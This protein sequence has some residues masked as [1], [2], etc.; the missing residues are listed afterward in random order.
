VALLVSA[1]AVALEGGFCLSGI[2]VGREL[3]TSSVVRCTGC[4]YHRRD[5]TSNYLFL[6]FFSE[7][8]QVGALVVHPY[9]E[10]GVT[11]LSQ[12]LMWYMTKNM[13]GRCEGCEG[14]EDE[15]DGRSK[16]QPWKTDRYD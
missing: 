11:L 4:T 12:P 1:A 13:R 5:Y 6:C 14:C 15:K 16:E 3:A 7:V 2:V 8:R 10:C 9:V